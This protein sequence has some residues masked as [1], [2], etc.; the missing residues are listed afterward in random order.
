M[1]V[2]TGIDPVFENVRGEVDDRVP[3]TISGVEGKTDR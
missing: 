2:R 3:M 1:L